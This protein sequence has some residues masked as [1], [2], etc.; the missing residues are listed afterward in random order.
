VAFLRFLAAG[1]FLPLI[2]YFIP[3]CML[4]GIGIASFR[5]RSWCDWL[6]PRG[7]FLDALLKKVS[8]NKKIPQVFRSTP[9]RLGVM[10]S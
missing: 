8:R 7:S 10:T 4:M 2:G 5:G 1:W 3:L 6:C 9:L